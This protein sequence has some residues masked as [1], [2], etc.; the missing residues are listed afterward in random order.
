MRTVFIAD[1]HLQQP[2]DASYRLLLR[3]LDGLAGN[4]ATLFIMGDLFEFWL[5]YRTNPFPHYIPILDKLAELHEGGMEF[6]YFEGN[7]DF[8][9]GPFFTDTLQARVFPG[10]ASLDI[11]GKR[12]YLCHGDQINRRDYSYHML[13]FI[14]HN[15]LTRALVPRVPAAVAIAIADRLGKRSKG[16]HPQ[17]K[18]R[19]DYPAILREFASARFREGYDAVI[20]GHFHTPLL[21]TA[22]DGSGKV[23]LC[24]GDWLTHFTYG[25]LAAGRLTLHTFH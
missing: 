10:P 9:L 13:R 6:V 20:T 17:R 16:S 4:T 24:L 8:H 23:L 12:F 22:P 1:A 25:E 2:T 14:F 11:Q 15:R 5:G 7:H 21:E 19:W 18:Q 3:F